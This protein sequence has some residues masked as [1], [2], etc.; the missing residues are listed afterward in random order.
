MREIMT[1]PY[2]RVIQ[3][4]CGADGYLPHQKMGPD[5]TMPLQGYDIMDIAWND[6]KNYMFK[7][8]KNIVLWAENKRT[9]RFACPGQHLK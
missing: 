3:N 5:W 7:C 2:L 1:F 8:D 9:K 4:Q 6:I